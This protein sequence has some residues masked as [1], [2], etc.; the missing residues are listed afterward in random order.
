MRASFR[1]RRVAIL[2]GRATMFCG[3]CAAYT[4]LYFV[5]RLG[6][7][8]HLTKVG[9]A[10]SKYL[11]ATIIVMGVLPL[12]IIPFLKIDLKRI[13]PRMTSVLLPILTFILLCELF[14]VES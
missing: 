10:V 13:N 7:V 11:F 8:H 6:D 12:F 5:L 2:T 4:F 9:Q 3:Q 1:K 14:L